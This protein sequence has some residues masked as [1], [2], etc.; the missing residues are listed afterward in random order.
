LQPKP[1]LLSRQKQLKEKENRS[2]FEFFSEMWKK[3]G[4]AFVSFSS[5]AMSKHQRPPHNSLLFKK[6]FVKRGAFIVFEGVDRCGKSTQ[7]RLLVEFLK[8]KGVDVVHTAFPQRGTPIGQKINDYLKNTTH[9]DDEELH[10]IFSDNRWE[11]CDWI[12]EHL[13]SGKTIVS[14]RYAFSG[15]AYSTAKGLD[16]EKCKEPDKG[17]PA[18][19]LVIFLDAPIEEVVKRADFGQ[20]RYEKE[21]FQHKVRESFL[22]LVSSD[23]LVLDATKSIPELSSKISEAV[24][25]KVT[26][27]ET[28]E[29]RRLW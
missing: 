20:E 4:S 24:T 25:K 12:L 8:N 26:E 22:K 3:G 18:P 6:D 23:W 17:L 2:F 19:D 15:V 29:I 10:L 27:S 1:F 5:L 14:D 13:R 16:F 28:L 21:A 11:F 7:S 9:I